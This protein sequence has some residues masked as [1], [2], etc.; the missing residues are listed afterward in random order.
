MSMISNFVTISNYQS[1]SINSLKLEI[2]ETELIH[3]QLIFSISGCVTDVK[4]EDVASVN[5][6]ARCRQPTSFRWPDIVDSQEVRRHFVLAED[7]V[8]TCNNTGRHYSIDA[9][10]SI[11]KTFNL[12]SELYFQ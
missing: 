3:L 10:E 6:M 12:Y 2:T 5:F 11:E 4:G 7:V 8:P 1:F 9:Y